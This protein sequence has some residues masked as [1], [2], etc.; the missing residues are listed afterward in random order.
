MIY[1]KKSISKYGDETGFVNNYIEKVIRLIDV[2]NYLFLNSSFKDKLILKGGTAINLVHTNL[3]RLSVDIDLDYCGSL[4]KDMA[5]KDRE[6]LEKELDKY[7]IEEEYEI[8]QKSRGSFALF[9]RIYKY[10][11]A[12]GNTD[13]IK[14][15]INFMDRVHLYPSVIS[16]VTYFDKTITIKTP[17]IEELF[18]MKINALIDRSKPRDLYDS[19]F[20]VNNMKLFN[21]DMLRKAVIF[22]LSLNNLFEFDNSFFNRI[23]TIGQRDIK[24]ELLPVLKKGEIFKLEEAKKDVIDMLNKLL[25]LTDGEKQYLIEFSKGNYTPSLLFDDS[26]ASTVEKHP[27]AKWR[28]VN[29]NK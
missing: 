17:S 16:S 18:G 14:V 3:K 29:M 28:V 4:D 27:M 20:L 8:S 5:L 21:K 7:M 13:T 19:V 22:Y 25:V 10:R 12:F 26:I 11:N 15:D 2:L 1:S 9:S 24:L 6:Q 23:N